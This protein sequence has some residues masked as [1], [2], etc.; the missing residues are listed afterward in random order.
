MADF[1][2][3]FNEK[4]KDFE[5]DV[6]IPVILSAFSNRKFTFV[7]RSPPTTW[8]LKRCAGVTKC[9]KRYA[10]IKYDIYSWHV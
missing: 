7:V 3:Q 2:K 4:T 6:P 10:N 1:C 8:F 9:A 5:K